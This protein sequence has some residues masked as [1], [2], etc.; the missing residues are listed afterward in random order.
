MIRVRV[1]VRITILISIPTFHFSAQILLLIISCKTCFVVIFASL[2]LDALR[3]IHKLYSCQARTR[4]QLAEKLSITCAVESPKWSINGVKD[5][6]AKV[7]WSPFRRWHF[8]IH[9]LSFSCVLSLISLKYVSRGPIDN[10]KALVQTIIWF[11]RGDRWL[12]I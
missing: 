8:H 6:S 4:E 12:I 10:E 9:F 3:E 7:A 11:R 5:A 2:D 1:R